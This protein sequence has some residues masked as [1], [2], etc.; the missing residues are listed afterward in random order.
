MDIKRAA[1]VKVREKDGGRARNPSVS[2]NPGKGGR[3]GGETK[4]IIKIMEDKRYVL[5]EGDLYLW[6]RGE[7]GLSGPREEEVESLPLCP[8]SL[9]PATKAVRMR[10]GF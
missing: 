1:E 9:P 4:K 3:G 7:A 10:D 6:V 8:P 5:A 2:N